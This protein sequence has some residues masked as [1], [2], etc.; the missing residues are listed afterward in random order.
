M[1]KKI[2]FKLKAH[3]LLSA[4]VISIIISIILGSLLLLHYHNNLEW[5]KFKANERLEQ[6]LESSVKLVTGD[7]TGYNITSQEQI[8]LFG[9]IDDSVQISKE[10]WGVFNLAGIRSFQNK[11]SISRQFLYGIS[12]TDTLNACLFL[13]DH[14]RPLQVSGTTRLVGNAYLPKGG[15]K[16]ADIDGKEYEGKEPV[17]G[18]VL[19]SDTTFPIVNEY[20]VRLIQGNLK[21]IQSK[22]F[23]KEHTNTVP[24]TVYNSFKNETQYFFI[25]ENNPLL[26]QKIKGK[27]LLFSDSIIVINAGLKLEDVIIMAPEINIADNFEGTAQLIAN[28]VITIGKHCMLKYPSAVILVKDSLNNYQGKIEVGENSSVSG[29]LFAHTTQTDKFKNSVEIKKGTF[30]EG[31]V[32]VNGY[33]QMQGMVHGNVLT[34]Y[35]LYKSVVATYENSLVDV[36]IDRTKLSPYFVSSTLLKKPGKL[37]IIKWLR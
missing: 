4:L 1:Q 18:E 12:L 22:A 31:T 16:V 13:V 11:Q 3:T 2:L 14:Q 20:L 36:L 21:M 33:L 19:K 28:K 34:D 29:L 9:G 24:D 5:A 30:F 6:N 7:S 17:Q 26:F 27:V 8:S 25:N 37:N 15:V 35:F 23:Q 32:F 10:Y